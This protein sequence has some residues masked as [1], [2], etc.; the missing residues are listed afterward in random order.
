MFPHFCRFRADGKDFELKYVTQLVPHHSE[1]AVFK[2]TVQR[3]GQ[4]HPVVVKFTPTYCARAHEIASE[5]G[6]APKLWFCKVAESVG[7]FVVAMDFI[8]GRRVDDDKP[9][10]PEK[11]LEPLR[12]AI[13]ALHDVGLVHGD[14]RGPNVIVSEGKGGKRAML[15]DSDWGGEEG[16]VFYP[17]DIN[18]QLIWHDGVK[19]GTL[20][21]REHDMFMLERWASAGKMES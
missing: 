4:N 16:H 8:E 21:R 13:S 6:S 12:G 17:A 10:L 14:L 19:P 3:D 5:M 20:I 15:V 2:A 7:M 1:K 9:H 11:V 18:M